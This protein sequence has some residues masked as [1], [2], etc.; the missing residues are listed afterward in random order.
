MPAETH[1]SPTAVLARLHAA[2]N[3]HDLAAFLECFDAN[4]QSAQ[5]VHPDRGFGGREQMRTNWAAIFSGVPDFQAQLLNRTVEG[6]TAWAEW[7][8]SG[9][10]LDG[11]RL[12]MRG[13]TLFGVQGGRITWGR[14]YM[15][16]VQ[17]AGAGIDAAVTEMAKGSHR[18]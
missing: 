3:Q 4:Y 6:D 2:T 7:Q 10:R 9:T 18:R 11:T 13:V 8:W 16:P 17:A 14:L 5:P 15:E 1:P 12:D